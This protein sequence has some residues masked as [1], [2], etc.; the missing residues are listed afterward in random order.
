M[1][2][3]TEIQQE[4]KR[5]RQE[6]KY[7]EALPLYEELWNETGASF[8]GAGLLNCLRKLKQYDKA[9]P[10]AEKLVKKLPDFQWA[11]IEAIWTYIEGKLNKF[12]EDAS[13]DEIIEIANGIMDLKPEGPAEKLAVFKVLKAAKASGDWKIVNEWSDKLNPEILSTTPMTDEE[14]R[15]MKRAAEKI[16]AI[17]LAILNKIEAR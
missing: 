14:G 10:L 11:K 9:I 15:E 1:M 17:R 4:A 12:E 3:S 7:D 13:V 6:K 2:T 5:L 8:D 16:I